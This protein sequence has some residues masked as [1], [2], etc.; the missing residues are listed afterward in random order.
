[1]MPWKLLPASLWRVHV[2]VAAIFRCGF[3][4]L[5]HSSEPA[6]LPKESRFRLCFK[7]WNAQGHDEGG[8][9]DDQPTDNTG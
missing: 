7:T 8:G 5:G 2:M 9:E 3:S 6:K 1:M 4:T